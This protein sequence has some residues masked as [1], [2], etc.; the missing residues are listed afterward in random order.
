[1]LMPLPAHPRSPVKV[2]EILAF[3]ASLLEPRVGPR[4]RLWVSELLGGGGRGEAGPRAKCINN[5]PPWSSRFKSPGLQAFNHGT[6]LPWPPSRAGPPTSHAEERWRE[7]WIP[8]ACLFCMACS[9]IN[10]SYPGGCLSAGSPHAP[11]IP[12]PHLRGLALGSR[13]DQ[14]YPSALPVWKMGLT[15]QHPPLRGHHIVLTKASVPKA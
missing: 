13:S 5:Q 7:P 1:M 11:G 3:P 15:G 12:P 2:L 10:P 8:A 4:A 9:L 6:A 14:A